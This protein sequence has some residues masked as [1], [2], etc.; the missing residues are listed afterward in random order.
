M[1]RCHILRF[2]QGWKVPV[3]MYEP[4]LDYGYLSKYEFRVSGLLGTKF[5]VAGF[6]LPKEKY[7]VNKYEVDLSDRKAP[8]LPVDDRL[9]GAA[10]KVPLSQE[11]TVEMW[12]SMP[13]ENE[14]QFKGKTFSKTGYYW[15]GSSY[16]N[17][18]SPDQVWLVLQSSTGSVDK[19]AEMHL[20]NWFW[21]Y[22]G[23]VFFDVF[24]VDTGKKALTIEGNYSH[25][26]PDSALGQTFWL[27]ERYFIVPLGEHRERCLVCDFGGRVTSGK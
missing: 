15:P 21:R 14:I 10:T 23:K 13:A 8:A 26:D 9:W 5:L 19:D 7:T 11:S 2:P 6:I 17:R 1:E 20:F 12:P 4:V 18:L 22:H 16:A 27:T 3:I 25:L 24:N